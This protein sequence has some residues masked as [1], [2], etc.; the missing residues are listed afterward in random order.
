[1]T[2]DNTSSRGEEAKYNLCQLTGLLDHHIKRH[3]YKLF[4]FC[5][6]LVCLLACS[7]SELCFFILLLLIFRQG[8][9]HCYYSMS[10]WFWVD[11]LI[12]WTKMLR[13][14]KKVM[15]MSVCLTVTKLL[16]WLKITWSGFYLTIPS[17]NGLDENLLGCCGFNMRF[18][19]NHSF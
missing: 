7:P 19:I 14:E 11:S 18:G 17:L 5:V 12:T 16:H 1:M 6:L 13:A 8:Q 15:S 9:R 2:K 4:A 10:S 3:F